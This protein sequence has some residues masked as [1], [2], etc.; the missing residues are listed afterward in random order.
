[1]I[2]ASFD[3]V[4]PTSVDEVVAALAEHGDDAKVMAGGHSLLPLMKLRLA[5]PAV[6][7]DIA[8]VKGS[9]LRALQADARL[10]AAARSRYVGTHPMAGREK[11]GPAAAR[12]LGSSATRAAEHR[13]PE[14]PHQQGEGHRPGL[15][16]RGVAES[17]EL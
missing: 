13:R 3:Y 9:I 5:V 7:V 8:S 12:R 10:D 15:H 17:A 16:Q 6:V 11:S 2:P 1:M 14:G 4:A